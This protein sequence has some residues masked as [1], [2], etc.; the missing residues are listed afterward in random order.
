MKGLTNYIALPL[1]II[2]AL[3]WGLVG[4]FKFNLVEAL[5]GVDVALVRFIYILVGVAAVIVIVDELAK[6]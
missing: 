3:N 2:G 1:V 5:F 4:L 6:K